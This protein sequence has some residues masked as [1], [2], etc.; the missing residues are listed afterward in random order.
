M[1]DNPVA[2]I[3]YSDQDKATNATDVADHSDEMIT[4]YEYV[5][6]LHYSKI[7][8]YAL[9]YLHDEFEAE[10]IAHDVFLSLWN[11][12][13]KVA[14][15]ESCF[16]WLITVTK[17]NCLNCLRKRVNAKEYEMDSR[18][19]KIDYIE[20]LCLNSDNSTEIYSSEIKS[21]LFN[22]VKM[23]KPKIKGTFILSRMK[24]FKNYEVAEIQNV[25]IRTVESRIQSAMTT[26]RKCF[27]DYLHN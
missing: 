8:Y 22:A 25:S 4:S 19:K 12:R 23:M 27:R 10:N 21:L 24:G 13:S 18:Q 20:Y 5:Y 1:T 9:S 11:N 17:N 15:N 2:I 3:M 16:P 7:Y 14:L 6:N 26:L